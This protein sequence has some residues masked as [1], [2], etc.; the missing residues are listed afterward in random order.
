MLQNLFGIRFWLAGGQHQTATGFFQ[1]LQSLRHTRIE[2]IF[3][4]TLF[5]EIFPV[6]FNG[7]P[8]VFFGKT[9]KLHE[10]IQQRGADEGIEHFPIGH[11]DAEAL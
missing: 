8:G 7:L 3:K 2:L 10:G 4:N 11:M 1:F 6:F 5:S 9:V